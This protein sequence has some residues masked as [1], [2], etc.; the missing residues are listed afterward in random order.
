MEVLVIIVAHLYSVICTN[1]KTVQ[2]ASISRLF[3]HNCWIRV[4]LSIMFQFLTK[5]RVMY[6]RR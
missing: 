6:I 1:K 4:L 5:T 3:N 2:M